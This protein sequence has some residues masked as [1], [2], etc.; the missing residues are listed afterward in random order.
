MAVDEEGFVVTL[1]A[2]SLKGIALQVLKIL[3]EGHYEAPSGAT[4]DFSEAFE[5]A[6][7]D[8]E[9]FAPEHLQTLRQTGA[10]PTDLGGQLEVTGETTQV[11]AHRLVAAHPEEDVAVLNFA[12][13][14]NPGGGFL[15]GA[16]AQE[17]D[18]CR[19]S[20]LYPCLLTQPTYYDLNR[21]CSGPHRALYTDHLIYTPAVPFFKTAGRGELLEQ[22]FLASVLTAPA[23]NSGAVL[24]HADDEAD[25]LAALAETFERRSAY[26]LAALAARGHHTIVLGAWGCGAFRGDPTLVATI[27]RDLLQTEFEGAFERIVFPV[28]DPRKGEP[29]RVAFDTILG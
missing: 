5:A 15:G 20:A 25:A 27:F 21:A 7:Q 11:A 3:E 18:V 17:E 6:E 8:T 29:N 4:I 16:R 10:W 12:S 14:K 9:L 26:V 13:A 22:P 23:P 2:M 19:C 1:A 28:F 24:K